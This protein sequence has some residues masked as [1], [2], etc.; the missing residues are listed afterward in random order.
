[1]SK[2]TTF[3]KPTLEAVQAFAEGT[4]DKRSAEKARSAKQSGQVPVGDV[5]ITANIR[6]DLHLKLKIR[7]AEERT[8]IGELIEKWIEGLK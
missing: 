2:V 1:M 8:T 4:S 6:E 7:A 5:R 3:R